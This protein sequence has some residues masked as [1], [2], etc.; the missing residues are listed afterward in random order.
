VVVE[1]RVDTAYERH[2]WRHGVN[3][4]RYRADISVYNVPLAS[5]AEL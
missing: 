1:I 4:V 2:R 3:H 5:G